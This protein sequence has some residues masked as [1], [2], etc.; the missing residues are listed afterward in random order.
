MKIEILILT[1]KFYGSIRDT[2]EDEIGEYLSALVNNTRLFL[3]KQG[4]LGFAP[5]SAQMGD[6]LVLSPHSRLP[7]VL[8]NQ[9]SFIKI[10]DRDLFSS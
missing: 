7:I 1:G 9:G 4:Y 5:S 2:E 3:T 6:C 10:L 8:R